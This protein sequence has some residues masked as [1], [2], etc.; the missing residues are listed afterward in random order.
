MTDRHVRCL[1]QIL[2]DGRQ[3]MIQTRRSVL[4]I[5][6]PLEWPNVTPGRFGI[7]PVAVT[8]WPWRGDA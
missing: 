1:L 3:L 8:W 5:G 2:W 4:S 6:L 7:G